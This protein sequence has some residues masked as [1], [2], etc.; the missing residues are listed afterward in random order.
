MAETLAEQGENDGE[1]RSCEK[2]GTKAGLLL[3]QL[4]RPV[5]ISFLVF[6]RISFAV[7]ALWH[8]W[9]LWTT[10]AISYY[11]IEPPFHFTFNGFSWVKPWTGNGMYWH[12]G[13]MAVL[14]FGIMIGACYRLCAVLFCVGFVYEFLLEKG[15]YQNHYYLLCLISAFMIFLPAHRYASVDACLRPSLRTRLVPAWTLWL[16]RAQLSIVYFYG[17]LAKVNADWVRGQPVRLGL[18][19]RADMPFV[20]HYFT[21]E[22]MVQFFVW[23]GLLF[24]LL[25]VPALLWSRTRILAYLVAL[26]FHLIN[27][28]MWQI[29]V[30]P[31]FMILATL[32]F[33][34][35]DFPRRIILTRRTRLPDEPYDGPPLSQKQ[36]WIVGVLGIYMAIQLLVPFRHYLYPGDVSW[37]EEGHRFAWHMMLRGKSAA[38]RFYGTDRVSRRTAPIP[39]RPFLTERQI[40]KLG[41]E[42]DMI[43]EFSHF[44]ADE[45]ARR[46]HED[47]EIRALV[48]VSLNGRKAQLFIDP[49]ID[50]LAEKR[51]LWRRYPWIVPLKEP[52]R[53]DAWVVPI[54][55][56]EKE[57]GFD[58]A[59]YVKAIVGSL[60]ATPD[61]LTNS[62]EKSPAFQ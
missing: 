46:G 9:R 44:L 49:M 5:D 48:L 21:E 13:I 15:L 20:G 42:P 3:R 8:I 4:F 32:I 37:T 43:L 14:A 55:Q 36:R 50:L 33:F 60:K 6:F 16:L 61:E 25:I 38:I 7:I 11:Y 29:G 19:E 53:R 51:G 41:K 39:V 34:P 28:V 31:W 58:T 18:A 47:I 56:W 62:N 27:S 52:L 57:V 17:G 10:G 22:W 26:A 35:P 45:L 30:F 24:D 59:A 23:G 54:M 2:R 1:L 12:F 40:E